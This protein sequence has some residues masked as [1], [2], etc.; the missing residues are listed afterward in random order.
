MKRLGWLVWDGLCLFVGNGSGVSRR[1]HIGG[2]KFWWL[3]SPVL[4]WVHRDANCNVF[5]MLPLHGGEVWT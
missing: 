4:S 1:L 5:A 2:L 3:F